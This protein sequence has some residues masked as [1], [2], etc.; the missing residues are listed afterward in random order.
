MLYAI[1]QAQENKYNIQNEHTKIKYTKTYK[2]E[3]HL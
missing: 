2:N 1:N 3:K